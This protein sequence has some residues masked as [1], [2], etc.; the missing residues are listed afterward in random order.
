MKTT[1]SVKAVLMAITTLFILA[2]I[3]AASAHNLSQKQ[4]YVSENKTAL[5]ES[6]VTII[7]AITVANA[8]I[9]EV[10]ISTEVKE[11]NIAVGQTE[12]EK[13]KEEK[14]NQVVY[15][16]LTLNFPHHAVLSDGV[17]GVQRERHHHQA[18]CR[19]EEVS[20]I[21]QAGIFN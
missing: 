11:E 20:G 15:D 10:A 12:E 6:K 18:G 3:F 21:Q 17:L 19:C 2:I 1:D 8:D 16:G 5:E 13:I 4:E 14:D 9:K 7:P